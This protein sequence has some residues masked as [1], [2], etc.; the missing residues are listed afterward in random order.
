MISILSFPLA[1]VCKICT[2]HSTWFHWRKTA[3]IRNNEKLTCKKCTLKNNSMS[4]APKIIISRV[5]IKRKKGR[6]PRK[7]FSPIFH[8]SFLIV[9]SSI[10]HHPSALSLQTSYT[11]IGPCPMQLV[12]VI[13]VRNAVSAATITF[14]TVSRKSFLFIVFKN[15]RIFL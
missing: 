11:G 15:L 1:T 13:A 6:S 3:D 14:T 10:I 7:A 9:D 5:A 2:Y 8:F 12:V 4:K